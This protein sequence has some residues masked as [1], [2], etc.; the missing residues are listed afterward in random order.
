MMLLMLVVVLITLDVLALKYGADSRD[1]LD[2]DPQM[3]GLLS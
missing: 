3:R 1:G 2:R